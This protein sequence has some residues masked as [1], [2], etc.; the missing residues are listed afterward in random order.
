MDSKDKYEAQEGTAV[1]IFLLIK[2]D[3]LK[4]EDEQIEQRLNMISTVSDN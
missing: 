3:I 4:A 2:C 1:I